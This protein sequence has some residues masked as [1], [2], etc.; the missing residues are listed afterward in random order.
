[1]PW[2]EF[3]LT[4]TISGMYFGTPAASISFL[5]SLNDFQLSPNQ[6]RKGCNKRCQPCW[7]S[8]ST[9]KFGQALKRV[10]QKS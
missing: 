6:S 8:E 5:I 1:M 7:E 9:Q 3:H 2:A 4:L 10:E